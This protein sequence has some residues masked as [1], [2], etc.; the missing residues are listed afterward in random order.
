MLFDEDA[1]LLSFFSRFSEAD[2]EDDLKSEVI[3][4]VG[5]GNFGAVKKGLSEEEQN[6]TGDSLED[7]SSPM[8]SGIDMKKKRLAA[9]K[10]KA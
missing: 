7:M 1:I 5:G 10:D 2:E 9:L 6:T 3:R 4:Y 8:D